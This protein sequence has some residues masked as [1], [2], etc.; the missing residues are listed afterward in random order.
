MKKINWLLIAI[1]VLAIGLRFWKL[2]SIPPSLTS[3]EASL[4]YNAYS[5]LKTGRDEYGKFLPVIFKSF[6]DYKPGLYIYLDVPFVAALGL[7][8]FATRLPS[9]VAGVISVY[10]I[11]LICSKL[12]AKKLAIFAAFALSINPW[13]IYFSRG[14]WEV[15][16]SLTLTLAG[17]YFFLKAMEKSKYF[18]L[19]ALLF[20]LT[21]LT[22]QGA[23]LSTGIVVVLLIFLYWKQ[24]FKFERKHLFFG[25]G[26]GI[27]VSIPIVLSLFNGQAGRLKVFSVFSYPR[28]KSYT[29]AFLDEGEEKVGDLNYYLF[30]SEGLN[31]LRGILGRFF[32][33]FSG[34]FLFFEGDWSNPR[35]SAPY[36]GMLLLGDLLL[37]IIG[38]FS[39][40]KKGWSKEALFVLLW[41][42]FSPLPSALSRDQVHAV[43]A[44]NMQVPLG[45]LIS[46]GMM[47]LFD[48]FKKV[49]PIIILSGVFALFYFAGFIYFLDAYF[50]H[51]PTHDSI[52]WNYGYK[53]VVEIV[54]PIQKK[55]KKIKVQQSF[56]QPYIYFLYY[57]KYDPFKYQKM[58]RLVN[59]DNLKDVGLVLSLDNIQF[60]KIDWN[61]EKNEKETL[62]VG[63]GVE[64]PAVDSNDVNSFTLISEIK[65]L[66]G[67]DTAFRILSVK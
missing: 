57:Q 16:V 44:L 32:N 37:V 40:I 33:H 65:Y 7:N 38:I 9:A 8:E 29:Q 54:T 35:Q 22:Y 12:F 34:K 53:Q 64:I 21:L 24:I 55:Y 19:S 4:G 63:D 43:R 48:N 28:P 26:L 67:R 17:I 27:V 25:I 18:I 10:L 11:Y 39:L 51:V 60:E 1:L 46:F 23:K 61:A 31:F 66:N 58:A 42:T 59:S 41:L 20:A 5:I 6:G 36:Q 62:F 13:S 50:V 2:G 3:D 30:H 52:Y 15:N 14:A 45:I 47:A 49:A 56:N